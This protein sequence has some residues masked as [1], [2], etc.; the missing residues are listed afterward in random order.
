MMSLT[1]VLRVIQGHDI[2]VYSPLFKLVNTAFNVQLPSKLVEVISKLYDAATLVCERAH[3]RWNQN[4]QT[5]T[6]AHRRTCWQCVCV[7]TSGYSFCLYLV[8][9]NIYSTRAQNQ[10]DA[11]AYVIC[12]DI[13]SLR[14]IQEQI[15]L[16]LHVADS[17][18]GLCTCPASHRPLNHL[19]HCME[20]TPS[21]TC[22]VHNNQTY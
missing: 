11:T 10:L 18:L 1:R 12:M 19:R 6:H 21:V 16:Y 14:E 8:S 17:S 5:D 9:Y 20:L 22:S 4:W 13:L 7:S 2:T 15:M 3:V